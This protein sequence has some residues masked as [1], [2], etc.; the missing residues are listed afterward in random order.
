MRRI[1]LRLV[2]TW[3]LWAKC[4][5]EIRKIPEECV[6]WESDLL[7]FDVGTG[8]EQEI[9]DGLNFIILYPV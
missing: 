6:K 2:G 7:G 1:R 3:R 4:G 5:D 9:G 8:I